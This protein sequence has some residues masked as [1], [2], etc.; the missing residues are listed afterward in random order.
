M[1]AAQHLENVLQ[2]LSAGILTGAIYGLMCVGLS[3]IF[4]VMRVINF[5]QGEFAMLGMYAAWYSFGLM[6]GFVIW[7]SIP[8]DAPRT[9]PIING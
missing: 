7:P 3:L 9:H 2:H 8:L 1:T 5:A 4:G 6:S